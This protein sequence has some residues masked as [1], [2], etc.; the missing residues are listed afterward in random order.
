MGIVINHLLGGSQSQST[1][2][3]KQLE[4]TEVE[5]NDY[6]EKVTNHFSTKSARHPQQV[7]GFQNVPLFISDSRQSS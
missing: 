2:I 6:R 5:L 3:R 4:E 1:Q 7:C